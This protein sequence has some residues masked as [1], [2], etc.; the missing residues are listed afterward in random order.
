MK[1]RNFFS[2][3]LTTLIGE[4]QYEADSFKINLVH[5]DAASYR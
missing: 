3:W 1:L 2:Q 4:I 5:V